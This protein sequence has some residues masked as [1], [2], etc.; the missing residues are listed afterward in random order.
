MPIDVDRL[1][2]V[3]QF[4]SGLLDENKKNDGAS[5]QLSDGTTLTRNVSGLDEGPDEGPDEGGD[6]APVMA[7]QHPDILAGIYNEFPGLPPPPIARNGDRYPPRSTPIPMEE[8][9]ARFNALAPPSDLSRGRSSG[10][11]DVFPESGGE[12]SIINIAEREQDGPLAK[13]KTRRRTSSSGK[14]RRQSRRSN[15]K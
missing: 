10:Q 13:R 12:Q 11:I 4:L 3:Y 1:I 2:Q 5:L 8:R 7:G 9:E 6:R 14:N 15:R